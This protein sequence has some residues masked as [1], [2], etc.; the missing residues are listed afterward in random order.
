[1]TDATLVTCSFAGD[2]ELCRLLCESI[3]RFV[4]ETIGHALFVPARDIGLFAG[5]AT[6]RRAIA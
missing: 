6:R 2:R 5:L 1:M 4:P 3:D